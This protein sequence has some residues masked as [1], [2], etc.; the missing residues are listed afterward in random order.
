MP[1]ASSLTR[2]RPSHL[3]SLA[4]PSPLNE[5]C[6][7]LHGWNLY[8]DQSPSKATRRSGRRRTAERLEQE[9]IPVTAEVAGDQHAQCDRHPL[10]H[11]RINGTGVTTEVDEGFTKQGAEC[12]QEGSLHKVAE[13]MLL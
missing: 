6:L 10:K 12:D 13:I 7:S 8:C 5:S 2:G 4:S 9:A 3:R 1:L 11:D